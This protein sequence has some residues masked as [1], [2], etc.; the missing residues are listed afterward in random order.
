MSGKAWHHLV[1]LGHDR[2]VTRRQSEPSTQL[3]TQLAAASPPR[4]S[5]AAKR[6]TD[7]LVNGRT[8]VSDTAVLVK[9]SATLR[10]PSFEALGIAAPHPDRIGAPSS[11]TTG[12]LVGGADT[13]GTA[14]RVTTGDGHPGRAHHGL[15]STAFAMNPQLQGRPGFLSMP[16][17]PEE[18]VQMDWVSSSMLDLSRI[19]SAPTPAPPESWHTPSGLVATGTATIGIRAH[20]TSKNESSGPGGIDPPSRNTT[21]PSSRASEAFM[22]EENA[23]GPWLEDVLDIIV[24][25]SVCAMALDREVKVVCQTLPHP[26]RARASSI[27]RLPESTAGG[28]ARFQPSPPYTPPTAIVLLTRAIQQR[29]MQQGRKPF[30][31]VHHAVETSM[32]NL[33]QLPSSPPLID[34]A[35]FTF[36]GP[37][38]LG[39]FTYAPGTSEG[40]ASPGF[41]A[42]TVFNTA[43][44]V[45]PAITAPMSLTAPADLSNYDEW[46]RQQEAA[47]LP[48]P[49]PIVLPFSHQVSVLERYIPPPSPQEDQK[50][51][52]NT[53]STLVDRL[54]ELSPQG[55]CLL[56]IYPTKAGAEA[57]AK[58]YLGP[59]LEPLLRRL[60]SMYGMAESLCE[61]LDKMRAIEFMMDFDGLKAK[62]ENVCARAK[63]NLAASDGTDAPRDGPE[64]DAIRLR[65]A[66]KTMV[67][68]N[69]DDWKEWWVS[70]EAGRIKKTISVYH[71]MGY[72]MP[73]TMAPGDLERAIMEGVRPTSAPPLREG[74]SPR[75]RSQGAPTLT[76]PLEVGV[77]VIQRYR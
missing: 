1:D 51:F 40:A 72:H 25:S 58:T 39:Y 15:P 49:N 53:S 18:N 21:H 20:A 67:H 31:Q 63:S 11:S 68:L 36:S 32:V 22:S 65:Y 44:P 71:E 42:R 61:S 24:S 23:S 4:S 16:T 8:A 27:T 57:F 13:C 45:M 60:M 75:P 52:S 59:I 41:M 30:I 76:P 47:P 64:R 74:T 62:I 35:C 6:P 55:G 56:F 43:V 48:S 77:F 7:A 26:P 66:R 10:L 34:G 54:F 29:C 70:Q 19:S 17:P 69:P 38:S 5:A 12:G 14:K 2:Q 28:H 9:T 37:T 50:I 3:S 46:A 73:G 33:D